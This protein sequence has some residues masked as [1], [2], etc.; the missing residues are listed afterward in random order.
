MN[1]K[2]LF[3]DLIDDRRPFLGLTFGR[4]AVIVV[5]LAVLTAGV[6]VFKNLYQAAGQPDAALNPPGPKQIQK[7]VAKIQKLEAE[8]SVKQDE[9]LTL[10]LRCK[11]QTGKELASFNPFNLRGDERRLL[12]ERIRHEQGISLKSLLAA[13]LEKGCRI[14]A[15]R[16]RM[17]A[18]EE[19]LPRPTIVE[20]GD[21]HHQIALNYLLTHRGLDR[22]RAA[23]LIEKA[24][25]FEHLTPGF[26]VW[27]FYSKGE[28]GTFV[29]QGEATVSPGQVQKQARQKQM[30]REAQIIAQRDQLSEDFASLQSSHTGLN[31]RLTRLNAEHSQLSGHYALLQKQFKDLEKQWNSLF[32]RLDLE[33]HLV[34][35]GIIKARFLSKPILN[36]FQAADFQDS[37]DLRTSRQ[38]QVAAARFNAEKIRNVVLYPR[39]YK[40]GEDY[41][42]S[43]ADQDATAVLTI[44]NPQKLKN[45]RVVIAVQ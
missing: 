16:S 43:L 5:C 30:A 21:T 20:A 1:Q 8:V 29:T 24:L 31:H 27:N 12:E 42:V 39:C 32:Y 41:D 9:V 34:K 33:K 28:F 40:K 23:E 37:I 11:D 17:A 25:L 13:I 2:P 36:Q 38:I 7:M 26:K 15:L 4:A 18:L 45:E 3:A 22:E 14:S 6:L 35:S 19:K 10:L 44:L